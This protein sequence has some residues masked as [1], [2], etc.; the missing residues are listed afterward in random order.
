[1]GS[2]FAF[3]GTYEA[4]Y[5]RSVDPSEGKVFEEELSANL[6]RQFKWEK[7][8]LPYVE[9]KGLIKEAVLGLIAECELDKRG[10]GSNT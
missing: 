3:P 5:T 1:M 6:A 10:L 8:A 4:V 9:A 7:T 2:H